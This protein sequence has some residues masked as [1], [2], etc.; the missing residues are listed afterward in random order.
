M[1]VMEVPCCSKMK[2]I[3]ERAMEK[4]GESIPVHQVTI[5]TT[6]RLLP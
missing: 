2:W 5:S 4:S 1:M 6:G 3:V